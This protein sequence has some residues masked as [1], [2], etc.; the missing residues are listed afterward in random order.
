MIKLDLLYHTG[1]QMCHFFVNNIDRHKSEPY[2][3]IKRY[4]KVNLKK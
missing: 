2:N 4:T 1:S 3:E